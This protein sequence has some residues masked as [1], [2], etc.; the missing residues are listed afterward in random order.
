VALLV[1]LAASL[2]PPTVGQSVV[3]AV[4]WFLL[5]C[6]PAGGR[7]TVLASGGN[8]WAQLGDGNAL[9]IT[10]RV[11]VTGLASV[12]QVAAGWSFSLAIHAE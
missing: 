9:P 11:Q 6:C 7:R 4:V 1:R 3:P 2:F 5:C 12:T 10:G 8:S